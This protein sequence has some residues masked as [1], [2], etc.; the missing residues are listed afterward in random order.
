MRLA[1]IAIR[2]FL[3]MNKPGI[4]LNLASDSGLRT[5][6]SVPLYT[7]TKHAIVGFT[8]SLGHLEKE[9]GIKTV[10]LCPG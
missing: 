6:S 7:A 8:R 5:F 4:I 9:Y 10:A 3:G 1:R 2:C